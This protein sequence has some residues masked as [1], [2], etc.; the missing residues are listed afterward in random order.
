MGLW[1]CMNPDCDQ[2][3]RSFE[4]DQGQCVSCKMFFVVQLTPVHYFIPAEGPIKTPFGNRMVACTPNSKVVPYS[5]SG[6]RVA[7][8]CP[9]C[10]ASVIFAEDE[11][12]KINNHIPALDQRFASAG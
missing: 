10:R 7:V 12:D 2:M 4:A 1:R 8:T 6:E 11:R 3:G 9:A 5:A